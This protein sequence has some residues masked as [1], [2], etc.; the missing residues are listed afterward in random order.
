MKQEKQEIYHERKK[1][2]W[3]KTIAFWFAAFV[4]IDIIVCVLFSILGKASLGTV[5]SNKNFW[6]AVL[7]VDCLALAGYL[8]LYRIDAQNIALKENDLENSSWMTTKEMKKL[9]EFSVSPLQDIKNKEDALVIGA[10]T[11][12]NGKLEVITTEQ[13]HALIVGTTGTGK[14]TGCVDQNVEILSMTKTK[15][16]M[17]VTDPKGELTEQHKKQL[18]KQGY[19]VSVLN[20]RRPYSSQRWNPMQVLVRRIQLIKEINNNLQNDGS[21]KYRTSAGEEYDTIKEARIVRVQELWDEI[22]DNAK[23]LVY[24]LCPVQNAQQPN[25]EQGA[26]NLIFALVL[27]MCEDCAAGKV[28]E[29]QMQLFNVYHNI[30]KYCS[31]DTTVLKEYLLNGRS[32]FS[33]VRGLANT[34]LITS[35]RTLTSYLS[36]VNS[37]MQQLSDDGVMS[38]LSDNELDVGIM[39]EE[40]NAVFVIFSDERVTRHRFTTLF[41][42]Q[43]YKEL[44]DKADMNAR[45]KQT[46]TMIL[47]RRC[48]FI[49]DEFGNLPK[50]EGMTN[51]VTVARSRGIRFLFILQS[52][53]QLNAV[54]GN[55]VAGIIRDNCNVKMFI[56]TDDPET[57]KAFSELC[58]QRKTKQLSVNTNVESP[59][60]SSTGATLQPLISVGE[61]ELLNGE[62]K[63]N[64]IVSVRG[65]RPI[66]SH[67]TPSYKLPNIYFPEGKSDSDDR[68]PRRYDKEKIVFDIGKKAEE[69]TK[70]KVAKELN[71]CDRKDVRRAQE[72]RKART[73]LLDRKWEE[74]RDKAL[75]RVKNVCNELAEE[76]AKDILEADFGDKATLMYALME[77]YTDTVAI[78]LRLTAEYLEREAMPQM[79]DLEQQAARWPKASAM[80]LRQ[81]AAQAI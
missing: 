54:Y 51:M 24:T 69:D 64:A 37:Y 45:K 6:L 36:E 25:W 72:Q 11:G 18:E 65:Y 81:Q 52:F 8:M 23:D 73:E 35:D 46:D 5:L 71:E 27:A 9:K 20:F 41:I 74:I 16:S 38:M 42:T 34:V 76:D 47:K 30:T 58:G 78:N 60:S 79:L 19:K 31:E 61:L 70:K 29:E 68:P 43:A 39:D 32:E 66:W 13:M 1:R 10:A 44:V 21:G 14:T 49:L 12:D 4:V 55:E 75:T 7:A 33:K 2:S 3:K 80:N 77:Q 26:R 28:Q 53:T 48:H 15:P 50:F 63:G 59:A 62:E 67:F 56:G 22:Y 40:P 17:I 57:R